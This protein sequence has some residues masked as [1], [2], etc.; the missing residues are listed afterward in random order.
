MPD[1]NVKIP[2]YNLEDRL[3]ALG[4]LDKSF[5]IGIFDCCRDAYTES[6]FPPV[7]TRGGNSIVKPDDVA[8]EGRNVFIIFGCPS[9]ESVPAKSKIAT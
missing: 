9:N 6:I 1:P 8:E 2:L 3:R 5:V 7:E 4:N